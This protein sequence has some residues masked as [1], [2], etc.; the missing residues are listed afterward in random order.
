[1]KLVQKMKR[2]SSNSGQICSKCGC[3]VSSHNVQIDTN[4]NPFTQA[5]LHS[6]NTCNSKKCDW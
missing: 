5:K 3:A 1:M 4:D 2:H 6:C